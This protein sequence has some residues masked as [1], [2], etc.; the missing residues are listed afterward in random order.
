MDTV[1]TPFGYGQIVSTDESRVTVQY[2]WGVAYLD[3]IDVSSEVTI[4][5][6]SFVKSR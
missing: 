5:V 4:F 2:E 3:I 1:Y 6:K